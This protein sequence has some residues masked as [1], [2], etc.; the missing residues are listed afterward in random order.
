M[1][2]QFA[3]GYCIPNSGI[4]YFPKINFWVDIS[5]LSL[6]DMLLLPHNIYNPWKEM[7]LIGNRHITGLFVQSGV[8]EPSPNEKAA[9]VR[10]S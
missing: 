2:S 4:F 7:T 8:N 9:M 10:L 5:E 6:Q 1:L 3:S